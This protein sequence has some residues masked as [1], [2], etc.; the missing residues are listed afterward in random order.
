MDSELEG[1]HQ[2]PGPATYSLQVV[3]KAGGALGFPGMTGV[4]PT[5]G[6]TSGSRPALSLIKAI[7]LILHRI[8]GFDLL[9][10]LEWEGNLS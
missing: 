6:L 10:D 7:C 4:N 9:N 1:F 2:E 3:L 8:P 5:N